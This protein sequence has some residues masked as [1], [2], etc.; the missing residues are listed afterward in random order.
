MKRLL[1]L[2]FIPCIVLGQNNFLK[3]DEYTFKNQITIPYDVY[4]YDPFPFFDCLFFT[5]NEKY[6]IA[7]IGKRPS[8]LAIYDSKSF[9]LVESF[10]IPGTVEDVNYDHNHNTIYVK[11]SKSFLNSNLRNK[12]DLETKEITKFK[13]FPS[14]INCKKYRIGFG[15]YLHDYFHYHDNFTFKSGS[16]ARDRILFVERTHKANRSITVDSIYYNG[17][18][19][20]NDSLSDYNSAGNVAYYKDFLPSS[21]CNNILLHYTYFS[22]SY[23]EEYRLSEWAINLSTPEILSGWATRQNNFHQDPTL[24]RLGVARAKLDD[25]RGSGYDRGHIVPA[26]DMK[27]NQRAMNETFNLTNVFPQHPNCNRGSWRELEQQI[28][29][30]VF[31]F[32]SVII[33]T[34]WI[35]DESN[36]I[37]YIG[38]SKIPIPNFFYKLFID[39]K[40]IRSIAFIL[41][42][43]I[44]KKELYE[45]VVSIEELEE[46]TGI[47]F[48]CNLSEDEEF[49][50]ELD[51]GINEKIGQ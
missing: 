36:I 45:Y 19:L 27:I 11:S 48:F 2:I 14:D 46:Y 5:P 12:I 25:Y 3:S 38:Q 1:V 50:Y 29:T 8:T 37:G 34:G 44:I 13:K 18:P 10:I 42:N 15:D 17:Y 41:P 33:I 26:G 21:N 28:R 35:A 32:D 51:S 49:L 20:N 43:D 40:N 22:V 16:Y 6:I 4:D 30:W 23:C 47:D 39:I 24:S 9:S 7:S 31:D